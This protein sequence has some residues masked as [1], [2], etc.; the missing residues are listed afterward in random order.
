MPRATRNG[1]VHYFALCR[2]AA[3]SFPTLQ[4][5]PRPPECAR[6]R[7][8]PGHA[9]PRPAS[10]TLPA[11]RPAPSL[12]TAPCDAAAAWFKP[13]QLFGRVGQQVRV[14][15][16]VVPPAAGSRSAAR[17]TR[18]RSRER[19]AGSLAALVRLRCRWS[20]LV[21]LCLSSVGRA[22]EAGGAL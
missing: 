9:P 3:P 4:C 6:C 12:N 22:R 11:P 19:S 21:G 10:A 13:Y 7:P 17:R 5:R 8:T 1:A 16:I 2:M 14:W 20:N 18:Q 15:R